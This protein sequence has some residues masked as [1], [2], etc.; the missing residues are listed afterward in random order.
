M[1]CVCRTMIWPFLRAVWW[2]C[3]SWMRARRQPSSRAGIMSS[4]SIRRRRPCMRKGVLSKEAAAAMGAPDVAVMLNML[5]QPGAVPRRD[6]LLRDSLRDAYAEMAKLQGEDASQWQWGKLHHNLIE[7]PLAAV[8]D[9]EMRARLNVGP[10]P[11]R[12]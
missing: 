2:P 5:E 11:K 3:S 6:E 8:V 12:G 10:L 1:P 7:H 4:V 9:E